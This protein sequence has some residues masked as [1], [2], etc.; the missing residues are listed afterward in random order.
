MKVYLT[1]V[2]ND[3]I[4]NQE[5]T[6]E[7]IGELFRKA[8]RLVGKDDSVINKDISIKI[9]NELTKTTEI[10]I[11][12]I[13]NVIEFL[14]KSYKHSDISSVGADKALK[15]IKGAVSVSRDCIIKETSSSY[16]FVT[17]CITRQLGISIKV[18]YT[19]LYNFILS[20]GQDKGLY[21]LLINDKEIVANS[22]VHSNK[23]YIDNSFK[24]IIKFLSNW[25]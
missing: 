21:K 24:N 23:V 16:S 18:Y 10:N 20:R 12:M 4:K 9:S 15:L 25:N 14:G 2:D 19:H 1:F 5:I 11:L 17:D 3:S 7:N 13:G 6:S 8:N 22:R